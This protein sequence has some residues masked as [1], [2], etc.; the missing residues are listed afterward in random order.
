MQTQKAN[1]RSRLL[2]ARVRR[3]ETPE[4][5][6]DRTAAL[7]AYLDVFGAR[8]VALYVSMQHEPDTVTLRTSLREA[9][10]VVLLP[11]LHADGSLTFGVDDGD[12]VPGLRG[13][14]VPTGSARPLTDADVVLVPA[15]TVDRSGNRL[16]RGGGSY[17]RALGA[18]PTGV[19]VI[20]LLHSGE[21][22][23]GLPAEPHDVRVDAVALPSGIVDL[24]V[25]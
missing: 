14:P 7:L 18:L 4:Q 22:V 3:G 24:A 16:G 17:D 8:C 6:D 2:E 23:D 25:R 10:V 15:L 21:L 9:G 12:C 11:V 5:A 20:A 19:P 13:I 1:L